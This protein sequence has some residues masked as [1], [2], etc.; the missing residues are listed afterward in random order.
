MDPFQWCDCM[1]NE[2]NASH[3]DVN[4]IHSIPERPE[5][6]NP[7]VN[8]PSNKYQ[9]KK[10]SQSKFYKWSHLMLL[11]AILN[12]VDYHDDNQTNGW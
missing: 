5:I 11:D 10:S 8:E 7:T 6:N 9:A 12:V 1:F 2:W 4:S 3:A